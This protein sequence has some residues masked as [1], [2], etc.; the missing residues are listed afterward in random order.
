MSS[1]FDPGIIY[2][3]TW[4]DPYVDAEALAIREDDVVVALASGGCNILNMALLG[5]KII[6]AI[7]QNPAQIALLSLKIADANE[8]EYEEYWERFSV[9]H[10]EGGNLY[11]IGRLNT[12]YTLGRWIRSACSDLSLRRF[13]EAETIESQ[14]NIYYG[15]IKPRLWKF[16]NRYIPS[17]TMFLY[18]ASWRQIWACQF[19]KQFFLEDL[20]EKR[21]DHL[22]TS[23]SM[24]KNY[25]WQRIFFGKY[26]DQ[27]ICPP[28]LRRDNFAALRARVA[29]ITTHT[30]SVISFLKEQKDSSITVFNLSDLPDFLNETERNDLWEEVA[31]TSHDG[32][33]ILYRNFVKSPFFP[34]SRV[35][36]FEF[37]QEKSVELSAK[38]MTG[39]YAEVLLFT[40]KK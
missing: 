6:H 22:F 2:N 16:P 26:P 13:V 18:G 39:S 35:V 7:D 38:E 27:S 21:L 3:Q 11:R 34:K 15:E 25:F 24:R 36:H 9:G 17:V 28:Y 8:L 29:R 33:R 31:R 1:L 4:E 37:A 40:V 12:L 10:S 20:F 14:K 32:A 23:S 19:Q 5:P 30:I